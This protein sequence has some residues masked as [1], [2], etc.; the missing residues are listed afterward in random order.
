MR[1]PVRV[2]NGPPSTAGV[3]KMFGMSKKR[4]KNLIFL[5]DHALKTGEYVLPGVGRMVRV[6]KRVRVPGSGPAA[7]KIARKW[8]VKPESAPTVARKNKTTTRKK[9]RLDAAGPA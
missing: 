6:K 8:A 2:P 4:V 1:K 3:A 5:V 7:Y 9:S